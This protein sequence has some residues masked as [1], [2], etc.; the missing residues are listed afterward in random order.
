MELNPK[1]IQ[2]FDK[3]VQDWETLKHEKNPAQI[4]ELLGDFE[5]CYNE[6]K[7]LKF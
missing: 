6:L 3:L 1:I 4:K 2:S 7:N 5:M